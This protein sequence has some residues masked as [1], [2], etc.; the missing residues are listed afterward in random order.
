MSKY[1]KELRHSDIGQR[2]YKRWQRVKK[3]GCCPEWEDYEKFYEWAMNSWCEF[4]YQLRR[5][6]ENEPYSPNN[7]YWYRSDKTHPD[8]IP[9][10][11]CK[12]WNETVNRVRV[13]CGMDPFEVE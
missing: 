12:S 2:L 11:F 4:G 6:N 7:C 13:A 5:Y 9:K 3:V 8:Y 1:N 10:E